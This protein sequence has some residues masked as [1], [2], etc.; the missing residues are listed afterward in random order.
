MNFNIHKSMFF[1]IMLMSSIFTITSNS[2]INMW[3]GMEINM[4][5]FIPQM[6]KIN[7]SLS[8]ESM[9]KYLLIQAISSM[10]FMFFIMF[11]TLNMKWF[12][13]NNYYNYI[14]M[15]LN[16]TILMK[17]GAAPFYQWFPKV[18]KGLNWTNCYLLSTWQKIIPMIILYYIFLNN[19]LIFS[20]I[21]STIIGS[22][23]G[24]NQNNLKMLMSYSSINHISW[25]ISSL[26]IN[27]NM[28][29]IYFI[30]YSYMNYILMLLFNY[31]QS[32]NIIQI[33]LMN[34]PIY[35]K[36]MIFMNLL[37]L[38]GLPPLLGF[39]PKWML[40]NNMII[41]NM[42]FIVFILIMCSLINLFYYLRI[43]FSSFMMNNFKIKWNN[44]MYLYKMNYMNLFMYMSMFMLMIITLLYQYLI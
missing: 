32:F 23:L 24:L 20:I 29:I 14:I 35:I 34:M 41:H 17:M 38:G 13:M 22:I 21:L 26:M 15:I 42:N 28:W 7:N 43:S 2:W 11:K 9:M 30:I 27:I 36:M 25:M 8:T 40:I 37:S 4:M 19:I 39:L 10:N 31:I 44:S 16:L 33:Y 5:S 1:M 18:M 12:E 6:M 3:L